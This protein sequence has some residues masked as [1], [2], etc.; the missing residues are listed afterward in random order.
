[1]D[2][3]VEHDPVSLEELLSRGIKAVPVTIWGDEVVI[4]FNPKE[5]ARLFKLNSEVSQVDQPTMIV[6]YDTVLVA[7]CRAARQLPDRCLDWSCP[8]RKRTLGQFTFHLFN[9]PDR[10]LQAYEVGH[11]NL[12]D[13]GRR[14]EDV[15]GRVGFEEIARYGEEV[16]NRVK[17]ALA[18]RA[19][20]D[21]ERVLD[22]Y[23]GQKTAGELM[24]LAL[25]HSVHHLK[26]LY[27]Y[28][29]LNGI[30]PVEKLDDSD[31]EGIAVPTEL[32]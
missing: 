8:E 20:L 10:A 15:I 24:D 11:Y 26:Q 12:D 23:M 3:D 17:L 32:F 7:A 4:G 28:M 16:L 19:K 29:T 14:V 13:R 2:G 31:F 21:L 22:T 6:K 9:R 25:G 30:T 5:L 1:M 18:D 27:E